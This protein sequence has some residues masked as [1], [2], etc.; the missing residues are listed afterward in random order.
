MSRWSGLQWAAFYTKSTEGRSIKLFPG[1]QSFLRGSWRQQ[2]I[3]YVHKSPTLNLSWVSRIQSRL[4]YL[5]PLTFALMFSVYAY[6]FQVVSPTKILCIYLVSFVRITWPNSK[7]HKCSHGM[8]PSQKS[9]RH[10]RMFSRHGDLAT[11]PPRFMHSWPVSSH[12]FSFD[13][14]NV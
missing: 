14:L 5:I 7:I 11:W 6:S 12:H 8:K 4:S 10:R 9:R 2:V 13:R 1:A 3:L